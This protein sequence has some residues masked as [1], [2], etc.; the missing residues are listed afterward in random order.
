MPLI[1]LALL[2]DMVGAG[3]P[4]WWLAG[5]SLEALLALAH[6]T[7]AM[8]GAVT[9]LPAMGRGAFALFL[10]GGLWLALWS[11][12]VRLCGL[13]PASL[14]TLLLALAH[15]NRL[16]GLGVADRGVEL[17]QRRVA[18]CH[19][20]VEL[21]HRRLV[22]ELGFLARGGRGRTDGR[23]GHPSAHH[24]YGRNSH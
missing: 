9:M 3:A 19:R 1:A 16:V 22:L 10:G 17:Q 2:A 24:H 13:V 15:R 14:G 8:P 23:R 11:G 7:A 5:K 20:G 18:F 6:W 12:T 4:F 21:A